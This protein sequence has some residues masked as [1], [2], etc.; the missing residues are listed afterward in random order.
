MQPQTA[1]RSPSSA[2]GGSA[3]GRR[4]I[5]WQCALLIAAGLIYVGQRPIS[6]GGVQGEVAPSDV[7]AGFDMVS[8][9]S[10]GMRLGARSRSDSRPG[11][12]HGKGHSLG[13]DSTSVWAALAPEPD[14]APRG[15]PDFDQ[16]QPGWRSDAADTSRPR[17]WTHDGPVA[18]A[19]ALW[20][21]D[22][23]LESG[24][25]APPAVAASSPLVRSAGRW[26]DHAPDNVPPLVDALATAAHT[27]GNGADTLPYHGTCIDDLVAA[28]DDH[29]R[30]AWIAGAPRLHARVAMLPTS[31][32]LRS[33]LEARQPVVLL[34]GLWQHHLP[35]PGDWERVGGHYVG[36][37]AIDTRI[38]RI[39]IAD[40]FMNASGDAA[41]G[42]AAPELHNDAAFAVHDDYLLSPSLRP[43]PGPVLRVD[44]Y[45]GASV[46]RARLLDNFQNHNRGPC[47]RSDVRWLPTAR[48]EAHIDA[49]IILEP[50]GFLTPSP[51]P[52]ATATE[53]PLPPPGLWPTDTPT[54]P[55]GS[56]TRGATPTATGSATSPGLAGTSTA[57][58]TGPTPVSTDP[59]TP[60]AP[61]PDPSASPPEPTG[62][63]TVAP[64]GSTTPTT[65]PSHLPGEPTSPAPSPTGGSPAPT[66]T[67]PV[68]TPPTSTAS[69]PPTGSTTT[70]IDTP[71]VAPTVSPTATLTE[72]PATGVATV[73]ATLTP[74]G[75]PSPERPDPTATPTSPVAPSGNRGVDQGRT[76]L[77]PFA[78]R[79]VR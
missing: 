16:R 39:R 69:P 68:G 56:A 54:P 64:P 77:L 19:A 24:G 33:A 13:A 40:P 12:N 47:D 72:P 1:G 48:Q 63:S 10:S 79:W 59:P 34:L 29:L 36:L 43:A 73:G 18:A 17:T 66:P 31:R 60:T 5:V 8:D 20:W 25:V 4:P 49:A 70:P 11:R 65:T 67:V 62:D 45:L 74:V 30:D 41:E 27:N 32:E 50:V 3:T 2:G 23:H 35:G 46:D 42:D 55:P 51:S 15:M 76:A 78:Y 26:D 37:Q 6:A 61:E 7:S 58:A 52:T 44:E 71:T 14:Y 28:L 22:S 21:L 53:T 38:D 9:L 75:D 57:T